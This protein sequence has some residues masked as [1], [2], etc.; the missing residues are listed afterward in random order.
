VEI[1]SKQIILADTP[2]DKEA[3]TLTII[4]GPEQHEGIDFTLNDSTISWNGLPL[5]NELTDGDTIRI[6]YI[7]ITENP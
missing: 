2:S 4:G 3:L 6:K 7:K 1:T 5:E